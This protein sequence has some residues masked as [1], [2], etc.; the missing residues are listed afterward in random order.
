MGPARYGVA[1]AMAYLRHQCYGGS[2]EYLPAE[3]QQ[4]G[5]G[6]VGVASPPQ[7]E[8]DGARGTPL[9]R[10]RR[11]ADAPS[12]RNTPPSQGSKGGRL[13]TS[14]LGGLADSADSLAGDDEDTDAGGDVDGAPMGA[15]ALSPTPGDAASEAPDAPLRPLERANTYPQRSA[16]RAL[17]PLGAGSGEQTAAAPASAPA[18][19]AGWRSLTG[20]FHVV[21]CAAISCRNDAAPHGIAPRAALADGCCDLI[22]IRPCSRPAYLRH[23]LR[24]SN[25]W[26]GDH[27]ELPFVTAVKARAVRFTPSPG[28][29]ASRWNCDGELLPPSA[30]KLQVTVEPRLLTMLA[31][32]PDDVK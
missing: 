23:L 13:S 15:R 7:P 22:A 20:P 1:G 25:P 9:L 32:V 19:A 26:L 14:S 18:T 6:S 12:P 4:G 27:L 30:A 2:V 8:E 3:G 11:A 5:T 31:F 10:R 17:I 16:K 29:A 24:L 28:Q 21:A